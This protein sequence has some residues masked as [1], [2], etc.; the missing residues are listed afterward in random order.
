MLG[1]TLLAVLLVAVVLGVIAGGMMMASRVCIVESNNSTFA[2]SGRSVL[3]LM[4]QD[5]VS[6]CGVLSSIS[7]GGSTYTSSPSG[8]M[9]LESPA[10]TYNGDGSVG[11]TYID[12]VVYHLSGPSPPYTLN[13]IVVPAAGSPTLPEPDTAI[14]SNIQAFNVTFLHHAAW[15]GDGSTLIFPL[16]V[17]NT[18]G[19]NSSNTAITVAG[20][21]IPL[22]SGGASWVMP[23]TNYPN[24]AIQL[25][26][27]PPM[28][29]AIDAVY[30]VDSTTNAGQSGVSTVDIG[31]T[32]SAAVAAPGD[33]STRSLDLFTVA[34]FR[35]H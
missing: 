35:N 2:S 24:G 17:P 15:T 3:D 29:A 31:L 18:S 20:A 32:Y 12:D 8:T 25:S 30:P 19:A 1:E 7:T 10:V 33:L 22:Q 27:A 9:I 16:D 26:Y 14:A 4:R 5:A 23:D 28:G 21:S 13:R 34:K 11:T 6:S